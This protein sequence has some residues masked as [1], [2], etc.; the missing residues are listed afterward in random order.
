[1]RKYQNNPVEPEIADFEEPELVAVMEQIKCSRFCG[2]VNDEGKCHQ[3]NV[4]PGIL[5]SV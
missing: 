2:E 5:F 3:V 1:L 4:C